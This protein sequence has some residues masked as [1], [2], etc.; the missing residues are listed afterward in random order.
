MPVSCQKESCLLSVT[1]CPWKLH[2]VYLQLQNGIEFFFLSAYVKMRFQRHAC[3]AMTNSPSWGSG[4]CLRKQLVLT[5][6]SHFTANL[7]VFL[8]LSAVRLRASTFLGSEDV[9][10]SGRSEGAHVRHVFRYSGIDGINWITFLCWF[11]VSPLRVLGDN[12]TWLPP[13]CAIQSPIHGDASVRPAH[14]MAGGWT[15]VAV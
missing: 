15:P 11:S 4:G 7:P 9:G 1:I 10:K 13:S 5:I 8:S 12:K 14:S 3:S 6:I 2:H